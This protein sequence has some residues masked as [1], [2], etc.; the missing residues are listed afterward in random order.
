MRISESESHRNCQSACSIL[1]LTKLGVNIISIYTKHK[2]QVG[3]KDKTGP[4]IKTLS[5]NKFLNS[6][7]FVAS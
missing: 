2:N 5:F 1:Y 6:P 3:V 7:E 4:P